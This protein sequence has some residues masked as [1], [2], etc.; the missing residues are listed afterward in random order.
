[1]QGKNSFSSPVPSA[2]QQDDCRIAGELWWMNQVSPADII[3]SLFSTL[4]YNLGNEQ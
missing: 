4:I 2:L 1:L 3:P